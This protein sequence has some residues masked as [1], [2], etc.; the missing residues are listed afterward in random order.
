[1]K[2]IKT[3][4]IP[5]HQQFVKVHAP[6][7]IDKK[8]ICI[9]VATG[10]FLGTDTYWKDL[11][12][13]A[14]ASEN[15][16]DED[17]FLIESKPWFEWNYNPRDIDF[18]TVLGEF[19][20]LFEKICA[21][22]VGEKPILLPLSG[23]LD[24]RTQAIAFSKLKNPVTAYSY[25][26]KN[27][28]PESEIAKKIARFYSFDF[29]E[30]TIKPGYLWPK[31]EEL[32]SLNKCYSEFTHPRQ[33]AVLD[34]LKKME[35]VIS[36]GHWGDVLFD[37]GVDYGT[38]QDEVLSELYKKVVKK[39]GLELANALWKE[40]KLDDNFEDYLKM[41]METM[42][43]SIK[44]ENPSAKIRAFKSLNW[45]P[46]WTSVNLSIFEAAHP[47]HLPYY[48]ERMCR[49]ICSVPEEFLADRKLQI[50]YIKRQSPEVAKITWQAH[51]PYNLNTYQDNKSPNNLP[52]RI[53]NRLRRAVNAKMGKPLIQRNWE[54]QFLGM[55]N[56]E[57][58][59]EHLFGENMHPFLSKELLAR[60]Y[61]NFRARDMVEY[62]HPLSM[63]LTL[64]MWKKQNL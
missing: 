11:K 21:E 36:L 7:E 59:Q 49:F 47:I 53:A 50:E 52:F 39:G 28:F 63:L 57:K 23:G 8:A 25:S 34:E 18:E 10:F 43:D 51:R 29:K 14:P 13:L 40:W 5:P 48:D 42:L 45:A 9:F 64:A 24:S 35:G 19:T 12:V 27:G 16:I 56:D 17:G 6:H 37:R 26:F 2:T 22:Q 31:L 32:S 58:L 20:E 33:M 15:T 46:R 1:L 30:F 62:S 61:N 3:A 4:I 60:F 41:R 44:I 55:E 38:T 54:L